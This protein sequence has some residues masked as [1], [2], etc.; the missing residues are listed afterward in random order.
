MAVV[1]LD[2]PFNTPIEFELAA[3]HQRFL[4]HLIDF[5]TQALYIISLSYVLL[6]ELNLREAQFGF[7]LIVLLLP[8]LLYP[9]I[10]EFLFQGQTLGK[11]ALGI[12]VVSLDGGEPELTQYLLRWF[13]KFFDWGFLIFFLFWGNGALGFFWLIG[14]S[15]T[16]SIVMAISAK[17]QRLGD[18]AARTVVIKTRIKIGVEDTIFM[19]VQETGYQVTFPQVMRLSDRDI[20]TIKSVLDQANKT[21]RHDVCLRVAQKVRDVLSIESYLEAYEFLEKIMTD[22][23]YLSTREGGR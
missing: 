21:G 15:I 23:N 17:S 13:L 18:L 6:G 19:A 8:T 3:W 7:V 12:R 9:V 5:F 22:Y 14:G 11:R 10:A 20:N 1:L 2:T 4:A 16:A